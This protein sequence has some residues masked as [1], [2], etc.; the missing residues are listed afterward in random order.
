ML[1]KESNTKYIALSGIIASLY[2][3]LC[4]SLGSLS[5]M[6]IQIRLSTFL[7]P[8]PFYFVHSKKYINSCKVGV[9]VG[10][11]IANMASP[12]GII[13]VVFGMVEEVLLFY[14]FFNIA[15]NSRMLQTFFY[16]IINAIIV[17]FELWLIY[18]IPYVYSVFTVG[19]PAFVLFYIGTFMMQS[20]YAALNKHSML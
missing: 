13:D 11:M 2:V 1:K 3:V 6:G 10:C 7:E 19:V 9:I 17:P 5:Y 12:L 14:V 8:I 16:T 20:V 4:V 15:K 18:D